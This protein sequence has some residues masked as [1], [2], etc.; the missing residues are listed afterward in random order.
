[1]EN[2]DD[3]ITMDFEEDDI[4]DFLAE[5]GSD[6]F[7]PTPI[8]SDKEQA[9]QQKQSEKE[10]RQIILEQERTMK[11]EAREQKQKETQR[12]K[13]NKPESPDDEIYSANGTTILGKDKLVLMK[14]VTQYKSLFKDELKGFKIKKN[15]TTQDLTEA[16]D[17]MA[18]LV[19]VGG[20]DEFY[21]S[22]VLA[23]MKVIEGATS[24]TNYDIRGCADMLKNNKEFHKLCKILF[25]KYGAFSKFPPEFQLMF[26]VST[27][28]YMCRNKNLERGAINDILNTPI[29]IS[30]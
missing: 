19:E 1:M 26:I 18:V 17:E 8:V 3:N 14:K 23:C 7:K 24:D 2:D 27:T 28:A 10:A 4:D 30:S 13:T 20:M 6:K 29:K 9:K 11:R 22:T 12:K 25:I 5:L 16:I 21:M 15:P